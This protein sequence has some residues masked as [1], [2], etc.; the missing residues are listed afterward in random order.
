MGKTTILWKLLVRCRPQKICTHLQSRTSGEGWSSPCSRLCSFIFSIY[1]DSLLVVASNLCCKANVKRISG[2]EHSG[3]LTNPMYKRKNK[4]THFRWLVMS[5]TAHR[6]KM[7][8]CSLLIIRFNKTN[9]E[10]AKAHVYITLHLYMIWT[11][12]SITDI[13]LKTFRWFP[14]NLCSP[15]S[16]LASFITHLGWG[17]FCSS[18]HE[19]CTGSC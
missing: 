19:L 16:L 12:C 7:G 10:I 18:S 3:L 14:K 15:T 5:G 2:G 1:F 6:Q 17:L 13:P 4:V 8:M 11:T 9:D